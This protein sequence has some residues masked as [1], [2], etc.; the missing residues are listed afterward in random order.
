MRATSY[1]TR[2]EALWAIPWASVSAKRTVISV[3][4][5][6]PSMACLLACPTL[7]RAGLCPAPT[8]N[9]SRDDAERVEHGASTSGQARR[10]SPAQEHVRG[11]RAAALDPLR[12]AAGTAEALDARRRMHGEVRGRE[13]ARPFRALA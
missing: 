5:L 1:Q 10:R 7:R 3:E 2:Y 6:K 12:R 11:E 8:A 4:K 9:L 13:P